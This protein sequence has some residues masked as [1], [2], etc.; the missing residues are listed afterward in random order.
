[1]ILL[2]G[3]ALV[4]L[5]LGVTAGVPIVR[6]GLLLLATVPVIML[7][8]YLAL[9]SSWHRLTERWARELA[10]ADSVPPTDDRVVVPDPADSVELAVVD[11]VLDTPDEPDAGGRTATGS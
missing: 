2:S 11:D 1:M 8:A 10:N 6:A 9:E 3:A 7:A 5:V 4:V